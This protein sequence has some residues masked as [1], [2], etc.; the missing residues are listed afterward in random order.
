MSEQKNINKIIAYSYNLSSSEERIKLE[1]QLKSNKDF[2]NEAR[3]YFDLIKGFKA[4]ELESLSNNLYNW[5]K[6]HKKTTPV[7]TKTIKLNI[8]FKYAAA[9][10]LLLTFMPLGYNYIFSPLT[11]EEL[12]EKNI[13]AIGYS[14]QDEVLT[15]TRTFNLFN[16]GISL[17]RSKK[18]A[19]SANNLES[20]LLGKELDVSRKQKA[21][22]HLAS[23]YIFMDK[24]SEAKRLL[25]DLIA[26]SRSGISQEAEWYLVLSLLKENNITEVQ[27][28]LKKICGEKKA[29]LYKDKAL[30]LKHQLDKL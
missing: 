12:F 18:Y 3:I 9:A 13:T 24:T 27:K 19:L 7:N 1:K 23:A 20:F 11:P 21:Q 15:Q 8:F 4:L 16:S 2:R 10:I 25:K 28:N 14:N 26:T 17:Y 29:H 22:L 5:E 30:E 6:K